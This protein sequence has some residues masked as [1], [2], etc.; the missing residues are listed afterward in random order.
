MFSAF[1]VA[2]CT[3]H[4]QQGQAGG[5]RSRRCCRRDADAGAAGNPPGSPRQQRRGRA[6][7]HRGPGCRQS[8][9]QDHFR[10][11]PVP[12]AA[13]VSARIRPRR[14]R[15][16]CDVHGAGAIQESVEQAGVP[17]QPVWRRPS[18]RHDETA[19]ASRRYTEEL[20]DIDRLLYR[21]D[22]PHKLRAHQAVSRRDTS[23]WTSK[24]TCGRFV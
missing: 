1:F 8:A 18:R 14:R 4:V 17:G 24:S 19:R 13:V 11:R 6:S 12:A 16:F 23:R 21:R 15:D 5:R 9:H 22:E 20:N 10:L 3:A 7:S 2:W